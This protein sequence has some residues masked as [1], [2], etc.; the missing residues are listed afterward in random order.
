MPNKSYQKGYRFQ[1]R[2]KKYLE[3]KGYFVM[4]SPKSKFPD[5][6]AGDN[7]GWFLFECKWNKYLTKEEKEKARALLK[8]HQTAFI[9]FWDDHHRISS[10]LLV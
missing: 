6:I 10:Y 2:V 3:E 7:A 8:K 1:L 9:V 4:L 5:G